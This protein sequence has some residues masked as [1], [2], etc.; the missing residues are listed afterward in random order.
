MCNLLEPLNLDIRVT[1]WQT[2]SLTKSL[3]CLLQES[4]RSRA[5][6]DAWAFAFA[7]ALHFALALAHDFITFTFAFAF[8]FAFAP[9]L[10]DAPA[11]AFAWAFAL[12]G[13][14]VCFGLGAAFVFAEAGGPLSTFTIFGGSGANSW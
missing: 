5:G 14:A 1:Q 6:A 13:A 3:P 10:G 11:F 8:A 9:A 12:P 4:P 2:H 7:F